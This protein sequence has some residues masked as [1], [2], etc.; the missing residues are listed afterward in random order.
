[1][2]WAANTGSCSMVVQPPGRWRTEDQKYK[3]SLGYT[4]SSKLVWRSQE[5]PW[6]GEEERVRRGP[7]S[8]DL[9]TTRNESNRGIQRQATPRYRR[10]RT[11]WK[12]SNGVGNNLRNWKMGLCEIVKRLRS[13]GNNYQSDETDLQDGNLYVHISNYV[14]EA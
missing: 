13:R 14:P 4:A 7:S 11:F 1:M 3:A 8:G 6:W 2:T 12:D 9:L 5:I 10:A